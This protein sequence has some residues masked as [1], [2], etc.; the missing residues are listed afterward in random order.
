MFISCKFFTVS[1]YFIAEKREGGVQG[2]NDE[3][4][5]LILRGQTGI[6][7]LLK[8]FQNSSEPEASSILNR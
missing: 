7:S 8:I 4:K 3:Q 6:L 2:T 1:L 5:S